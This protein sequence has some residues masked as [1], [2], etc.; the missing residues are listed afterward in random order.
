[1]EMKKDPKEHLRQLYNHANV[2]HNVAWEARK[3]LED[4]TDKLVSK[5]KTEEEFN[6]ILSCLEET[7]FCEQWD[8]P[9]NPKPNRAYSHSGNIGLLS[10]EA[11]YKKA[12]MEE[13]KK[14][15]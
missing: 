1:M 4:A 6:D 13:N 5:C 11:H 2:L 7:L 12:K 3:T 10:F 14:P 9:K 8:F 15:A